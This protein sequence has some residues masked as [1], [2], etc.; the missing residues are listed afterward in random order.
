MKKLILLILLATTALAL[1]EPTG[2]VN[3]YAEI[4]EPEWETQITSSINEIQQNTTAE[5]SVIT[6]K[7][8][9]GKPVEEVALQYLTAWG[10]GKAETDNGIVILVS[11][12]DRA[13]RIETGYGVEGILPDG[14]AG[15]IGRDILQLYFRQELYGEGIYHTV[16][17]IGALLKQ[18]PTIIAKYNTKSVLVKDLSPFIIFMNFWLI[19]F[20]A[21]ICSANPKQKRKKTFTT[22]NAIYNGLLIIIGIMTPYFVLTLVGIGFFF[23]GLIIFNAIRPA[24]GGFHG[25]IWWGGPGGFGGMGRG[26]GG[27]GSSGF[28]G[29]LGGGGGASG[30]W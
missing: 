24:P 26:S 2:W 25:P 9:E 21:G 30:G 28:G 20:T 13:Y 18:D 22:L 3:D 7:N 29:G 17:E 4:I 8:L 10:V 11:L 1:P 23:I 6:V 27:F 19:M 12:E 14:R 15:R 5:I 16:N